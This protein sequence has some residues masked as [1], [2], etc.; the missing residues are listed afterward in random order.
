MHLEVNLN[1]N[2]E[3]IYVQTYVG[4]IDFHPMSAINEMEKQPA[5]QAK[6]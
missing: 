5:T 3:Q 4:I 2:M 1:A 6:T